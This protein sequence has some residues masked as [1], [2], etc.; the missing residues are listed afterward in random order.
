[1]DEIRL[2]RPL[3]AARRSLLPARNEDG[4]WIHLAHVGV[5]V[6]Y[7]EP[8]SRGQLADLGFV[9]QVEEAGIEGEAVGRIS[10]PPRSGPASQPSESG[11]AFRSVYRA[12]QEAHDQGT[13]SHRGDRAERIQATGSRSHMRD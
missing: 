6:T 12:G 3:F 5:V 1:L 4:V 11:L 2:G 13:S 7:L 10:S 8:R 9:D